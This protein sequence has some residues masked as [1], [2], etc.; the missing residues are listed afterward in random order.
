[1]GRSFALMADL[2]SGSD[3]EMLGAKKGAL[4]DYGELRRALV[5][6]P[7]CL[8]QKACLSMLSEAGN[9]AGNFRRQCA[10]S[11]NSFVNFPELDSSPGHH[12]FVVVQ[13]ITT[14]CSRDIEPLLSSN[15]RWNYR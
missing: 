1:M 4:T 7:L 5:C 2:P 10:N 6:Y 3:G 13:L 14:P 9:S 8:Q 12:L 15:L 11:W